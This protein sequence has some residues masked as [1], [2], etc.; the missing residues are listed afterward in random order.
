MKQALVN[1][2]SGEVMV[3]DVPPPVMKG[4][5]V[6]VENHFSVI[7]AGTE[8]MLINLAGSSYIGK[9]RQK[10]DM[11][12][13]VV[14]LAKKQ[15]PITAYKAVT[16]RLDKPEPMGYSCA[17]IVSKTSENVPFNKGD[18][19]ACGGV[20]YANHADM[21][22]VPKNLCVKVPDDVSLRDA[23]F[24][25]LGSIAM[26][27]VR[28]ADVRVGEKVAV[29]GLGLIGQLTVQI[30]KASGCEVFGI[31]IDLKKIELGKKLGLDDGCSASAENIESQAESF[32]EGVGFD[33]VIITAATRSNAPLELAGKISR[34]KGRV[35]L[36]GLSGME[37][38]RDIYYPKELEF[39]ISCSYGP[40]RYDPEY[41]EMGHDYPI[42]YV[43]WTEKR[44]MEAFLKLLS[45]KKIILDDLVSHEFH[46][47]KAA[48][49]YEL[50]SS[51]T[52][53]P[54]MGIVLTYD[55][56]KDPRE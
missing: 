47:E 39:V 45:Q 26:Q 42:G 51:K 48:D 28:N 24:T 35:V 49:A 23:S 4:E 16:G 2:R 41:E 9:A 29:I 55:T 1:L 15:G 7:S 38:P 54:Y 33:A 13:K 37:I 30:L 25:T 43:R 31:E 11:F 12:M 5:G 14:E 22:F 44:N 56:K 52:K 17:G 46:I 53:K 19:V 50:I 40:G 34:K 10:P 8:S 6:L 36:V 20:G 27:G 32:I 3:E 21:V 18:R